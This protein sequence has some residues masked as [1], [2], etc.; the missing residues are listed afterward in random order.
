MNEIDNY[1]KDYYKEDYSEYVRIKNKID[2]FIKLYPIDNILDLS[3]DEYL[4][5]KKGFGNNRSF[6]NRV[7]YDFEE[8]ASSGNV[9]FDIFGIFL[10]EGTNITL[11]PTFKNM[12]GNDYKI[13]FDYIKKLIVKLL[14]E[15]ECGNYDYIRKCKLNSAFKYRLL[16]IYFPEMLV[17]VTTKDTLNAYCDVL[18]LKYNPK[19]E[20]IYRNIELSKTKD[21]IYEM[22]NWT[23]YNLMSFA[24]RLWRKK[25]IIDS[26]ELINKTSAK[27][28]KK[29][30]NDIEELELNGIEKEAIVKVRVNQSIFRDRL[31]T[32]YKRCCLCNVDSKN[33]LIASHIK[34]WSVSTSKEKLD[35]N[36]GFLLCPNHDKLFDKGYITFD[37][38]GKILIS[39][40]LSENQYK[41]LNINKKIQLKLTEGNI[42]YLNYHRKN[43]FKGKGE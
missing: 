25:K 22:N 7:R 8:L 21:S 20:M 34:P 1:N 42:K 35:I 24:D 11:S 3:L 38:T 41:D 17:P 28:A 13:A 31:I 12:Y 19:E 32:R 27:I 14:K 33:M 9:R 2:S 30:E 5:A 16:I 15:F 26:N 18:N 4:I 36:N 37:K 29:I 23:N 10:N 39:K 6:C 40:E 43:V